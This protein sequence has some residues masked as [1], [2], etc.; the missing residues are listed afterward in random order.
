MSSDLIALVRETAKVFEENYKTKIAF[1]EA[2]DVAQNFSSDA[3]V[4]ILKILQEALRNAL[5][6]SRADKIEIKMI[7]TMN[8]FILSVCDN[9]SGFDVEKPGEKN[10]TCR[11]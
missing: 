11:P 10:G 6:H 4:Q 1:Y 2:S 8:D 5:K 9:G 3:K 7:D